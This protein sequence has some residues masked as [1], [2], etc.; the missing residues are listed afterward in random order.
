VRLRDAIIDKTSGWLACGPDAVAALAGARLTVVERAFRMGG[1]DGV[2][3]TAEDV[4]LALSHFGYGLSLGHMADWGEER[5]LWWVL[6]FFPGDVPLIIAIEEE[7]GSHWIATHGW[8]L[9]D[10]E[11][12]GR[13][14]EWD[15]WGLHAAAPVSMVWLVAPG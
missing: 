3:T 9:A 7:R 14:I 12:Y 2:S 13:W 4:A 5:P 15:D 11:T 8:W 1:S 10:V 6:R